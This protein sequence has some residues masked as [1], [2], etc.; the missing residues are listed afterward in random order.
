MELK[1]VFLF[2]GLLADRKKGNDLGD[3]S[4]IFVGRVEEFHLLKVQI[5]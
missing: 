3:T 1:A 4:L 5:F 2:K